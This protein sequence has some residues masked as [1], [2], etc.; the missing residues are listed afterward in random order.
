MKK[1]ILDN[2]LENDCIVLGKLE[3][4]FLLLMNN[5]LIPWFILVPETTESELIDLSHPEQA[6]LLK[7]I[8]LISGF[9]RDNY[10]CSKL[11]IATIGNIVNQL[12]VHVIGRSPTDYCWPNVVWGTTE[13]KPYLDTQVDEILNLLK[14]QLGSQF[15]I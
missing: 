2:R 14:H 9:I 13:K 6:N 1:F 7:E 8:N 5:A 10:D 4:S 3:I 11:N 12:H 15:K